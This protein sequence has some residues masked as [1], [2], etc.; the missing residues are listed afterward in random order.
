[1]TKKEKAL[2]AVVVLG[3]F[4]SAVYGFNAVRDW[5][6]HAPERNRHTVMEQAKDQANLAKA[7]GLIAK[8]CEENGGHMAHHYSSWNGLQQDCVFGKDTT[9]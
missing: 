8:A 7:Y 1:M 5:A 2:L 4:S 9:K 6:S 3:L